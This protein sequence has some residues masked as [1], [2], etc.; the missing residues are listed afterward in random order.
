[1]ISLL[2][3]L[4]IFDRRSSVTSR[5]RLD[6]FADICVA[7][8]VFLRLSLQ[9]LDFFLSFKFNLHGSCSLL[10]SNDSSLLGWVVKLDLHLVHF[11]HGWLR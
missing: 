1:M 8:W 3:Q 6:Q 2:L 11:L 10:L 5:S 9:T 4:S 7:C